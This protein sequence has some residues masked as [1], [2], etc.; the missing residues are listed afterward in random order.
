[1]KMATP[2]ARIFTEKWSVSIRLFYGRFDLD[3]KG[4]HPFHRG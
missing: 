3:Q 1:M 4:D 2:K